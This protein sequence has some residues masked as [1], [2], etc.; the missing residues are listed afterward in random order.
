[1]AATKINNA[2]IEK[3]IAEQENIVKQFI[4]DN[5]AKETVKDSPLKSEEE[6]IADIAN[7]VNDYYN[8]RNQDI[9]KGYELFLESADEQ[10]KSRVTK[11]LENV[12]TIAH[13]AYQAL[14]QQKKGEVESPKPLNQTDYEELLSK[15]YES[16]QEEVTIFQTL[17]QQKLGNR[18][19]EDA[20]CMFK[21]IINLFFFY[22][23]AWIGWALSEAAL[24]NF[25]IS[26]MAFTMALQLFPEDNLVAYYAADFYFRHG[27]I[28]RAVQI[29]N[30]AKKRLEDLNQQHLEV[31]K[32][33][34]NLLNHQR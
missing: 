25:V 33:V 3:M 19:Y 15:I 22:S 26:D 27:G 16:A 13:N 17:A 6:Q 5:I 20:S 34:I 1:M 14:N 23:P 30:E 31:Y 29:L 21:F 32:D 24:G 11:I 4:I 7:L 28:E 10:N 12:Q 2:E 8:V 9:K 18:E